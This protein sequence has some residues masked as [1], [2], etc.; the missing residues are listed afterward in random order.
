MTDAI[1]K[2]DRPAKGQRWRYTANVYTANVWEVEEP[3][4]RFDR[5]VLRQV[6]GDA[7][8]G[9]KRSVEWDRLHKVYEYLGEFSLPEGYSI[10]AVSKRYHCFR[11]PFGYVEGPP[12]G[13]GWTWRQARDAAVEHAKTN[14]PGRRKKG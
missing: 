14:S 6:Q 7:A 3:R 12:Q 5:V 1:P 9:E 4:G 10:H 11:D 8:K 2:P 13:Q